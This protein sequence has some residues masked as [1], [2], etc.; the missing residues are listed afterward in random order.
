MA[1]ELTRSYQGPDTETQTYCLRTITF[2]LQRAAGPYRSAS[3]MP[4]QVMS[5][6]PRPTESKITLF[7]N[8]RKRPSKTLQR[9]QNTP[10]PLRFMSGG[11]EVYAKDKADALEAELEPLVGGSIVAEMFKYDSD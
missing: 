1:K 11:E 9:R 4:S 5:A 3:S 7:M 8:G 6:R 2:G 10:S